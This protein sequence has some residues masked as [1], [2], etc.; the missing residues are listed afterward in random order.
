MGSK[1]MYVNPEILNSLRVD[2][3]NANF[4]QLLG[5]SNIRYLG[6]SLLTTI[7]Q[8]KFAYQVIQFEHTQIADKNNGTYKITA[9]KVL[10]T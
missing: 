2:F 4:L 5:D 1:I 3:C 8:K 6:F 10:P 7:S 9:I